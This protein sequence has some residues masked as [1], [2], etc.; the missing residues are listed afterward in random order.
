MIKLNTRAR[1]IIVS[2]LTAALYAVQATLD[3]ETYF[4][5]ES[6]LFSDLLKGAVLGAFMYIGVFWALFFKVR[7]ERLITIML[8]PSFGIV[9]L[10][11][12]LQ[13]ILTSFI[14]GI[15]QI[16]IFILS[17]V[18]I[19][20]FTY[21]NLLS[22]NILNTS[23]LQN[24]PLA[25][26]AKAAIFILSLLDGFLIFFLLFTNDINILYRISGVFL[27][28][29]LLSYISLWSV[30]MF[31]SEKLLTAIAL[32]VLLTFIAGAISI[33]PI[34]APY[35]ALTLTLIFY[36]FMNISL[37]M[38]EII[39]EYIWLEYAVIFSLIL[40]LLLLLSEWG[41]NGLL[42]N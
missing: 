39:S 11:I 24:I 32:A 20:I 21:I 22:V 38:R 2:I 15:G 27:T 16:P 14:G 26:A 19:G 36:I 1:V 31:R 4:N 13:L 41:I 6:K 40:L 10:S 25:Q 23:Y 28:V 7:G 12:L 34:S 42:I 5:L 37:E 30:D 18:I 9:A 33:W 35:L 8:F 29:I 3:Y 17:L